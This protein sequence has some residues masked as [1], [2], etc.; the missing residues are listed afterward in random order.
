MPSAFHSI[1]V[2]FVINL[3]SRPDRM[4]SFRAMASSLP[5]D[6]ER[7]E[8]IGP[9]SFS[10]AA[11]NL[12]SI[13]MAIQSGILAGAQRMAIFEDDACMTRECINFPDLLGSID[14]EL[15]RL[16]ERQWQIYLLG[17]GSARPKTVQVATSRSVRVGKCGGTHA[18]ILSQSGMGAIHGLGIRSISDA[19]K[20]IQAA[21]KMPDVYLT[22]T[23]KTFLHVPILFHQRAGFSDIAQKI[24][25]P[26]AGLDRYE[27]ET[28]RP[29]VS[30]A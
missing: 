16:D 30:G 21:G 25:N 14:E 3:A 24:T 28:L 13:A 26:A 9:D 6:V 19:A 12:A 1:P 5:F 20:L 29:A 27:T 11:G 8:A 4:E 22:S 23:F 15:D 17:I 18:F 10:P 2:R 7:L